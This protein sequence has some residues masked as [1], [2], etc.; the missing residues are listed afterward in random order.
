MQ[1]YPVFFSCIHLGDG[2]VGQGSNTFV[3]NC[4]MQ[5]CIYVR[6][7]TQDVNTTEF[8]SLKPWVWH[9]RQ[10]DLTHKRFTNIV[11]EMVIPTKGYPLLFFYQRSLLY[12]HQFHQQEILCHCF[13]P[14][15]S[16][17][18]AHHT[19]TESN[20]LSDSKWLLSLRPGLFCEL[21]CLAG[22]TSAI[23]GT[24]VPLSSC[25]F[26][27][28]ARWPHTDAGFMVSRWSILINSHLKQ[29]E[30]S[31]VSSCRDSK[32]ASLKHKHKHRD[33]YSIRAL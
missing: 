32:S 1:H 23:W 31:E 29:V 16:F 3:G 9:S 26:Y 20:L 28:A 19:D 24:L 33:I 22:G 2:S 18:Q 10:C 8:I 4:S 6:W 27:R 11:S 7:L 12:F 15:E 30:F 17:L 14:T 21:N 25:L 5:M 13:K